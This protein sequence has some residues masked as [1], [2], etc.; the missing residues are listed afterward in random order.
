PQIAQLSKRPQEKPI[1][2]VHHLHCVFNG[3]LFAYARVLEGSI[4]AESVNLQVI[5]PID[6]TERSSSSAKQS[7][8]DEEREDGR[9]SRITSRAMARS[10]IFKILR[11]LRG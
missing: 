9:R 10:S 3:V 4:G 8:R 5:A 2:P 11:A 6:A 7:P 1:V